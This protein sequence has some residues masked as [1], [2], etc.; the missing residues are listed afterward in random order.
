[1][2]DTWNLSQCTYFSYFLTL[3]SSKFQQSSSR[4]LEL[5]F[6]LPQQGCSYKGSR[7]IFVIPRSSDVSR[8]F[9]LPV[10]IPYQE[11]PWHQAIVLLDG[12]WPLVFFHCTK[13]SSVF[14]ATSASLSELANEQISHLMAPLLLHLLSCSYSSPEVPWNY[15]YSAYLQVFMYTMCCA[16][17]GTF[18][19]YLLHDS[20]SPKLSLRASAREIFF[21]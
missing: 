19:F 21:D 9:R 11:W 5:P 12:E 3:V 13:M 6:P 14:M 10:F 1:M 8:F 17:P 18:F 4:F 16:K 7:K 15:Q 20:Q 2:L